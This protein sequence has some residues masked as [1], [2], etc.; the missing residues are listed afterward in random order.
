MSA[1]E[2]AAFTLREGSYFGNLFAATPRRYACAGPASAIPEITNRFCSREKTV[3]GSSSAIEVLG[4]CWPEGCA[5]PSVCAG[6]GEHDA[7][8]ECAGKGE[9]FPEVVTVFLRPPAD[10]PS[11][12]PLSGTVAVETPTAGVRAWLQCG[13]QVAST[14]VVD[15]TGHVLVGG[16]MSASSIDVGTGPLPGEST[17]RAH[18]VARLA[19]SGTTLWVRRFENDSTWSSFDMQIAGAASGGPVLAGVFS[20]TVKL[21]GKVLSTGDAFAARLSESGAVLWAAPLG[22]EAAV[23]HGAVD[24]SGNDVVAAAMAQVGT[25]STAE[26]GDGGAPCAAS[27][28]PPVAVHVRKYTASGGKG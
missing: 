4:V 26:S 9:F 14:V 24:G 27:K 21:D 17:T 18:W 1:E 11:W 6:T 20:G 23:A 13:H 22:V 10:E 15:A 5:V 3:G 12:A 19:P 2:A 28:T 8:T 25:M 7:S 16:P